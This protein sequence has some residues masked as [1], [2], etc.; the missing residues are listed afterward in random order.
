MDLFISVNPFVASGTYMS[1]LHKVFQV[2]L[3]NIIPLF[4]MLPSTLKYLYSV[5]PIRMHFPTKQPC[6]ND[7]IA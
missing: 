7:S 2:R 5:E 6:T 4:S 3:D 1:H